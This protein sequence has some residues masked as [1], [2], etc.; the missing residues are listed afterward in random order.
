MNVNRSQKYGPIL[1][2]VTQAKPRTTK[3]TVMDHTLTLFILKS[4]KNLYFCMNFLFEKLTGNENFSWL[5]YLKS[6]IH[7]DLPPR[8]NP[9]HPVS[10]KHNIE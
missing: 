3:I 8:P 1:H 7:T 6:F 4:V 5:V 2:Y 10:C 9:R